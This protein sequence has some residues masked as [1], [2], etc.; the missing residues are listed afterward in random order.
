MIKYWVQ[1]VAVMTNPSNPTEQMQVEGEMG[2]VRKSPITDFDHVPL[3]AKAVAKAFCEEARADPEHTKI[4]VK[5]WQ[6]FED[7]SNILVV[8]RTN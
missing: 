4:R 3:V 8:P 5:S 7:E 6:R 1:F 2:V